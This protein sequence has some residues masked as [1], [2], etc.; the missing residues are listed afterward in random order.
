MSNGRWIYSRSCW[1][2]L[3]RNVDGVQRIG[4]FSRREI[5]IGDEITMDYNFSHF[6]EAVAC[7]CGTALCR[8]K[9]GRI[10]KKYSI[11]GAP[12][13]VDEEPQEIVPAEIKR[14]VHVSSLALLKS[15]QVQ[16]NCVC[17]PSLHARFSFSF[18]VAHA[19]RSAMASHVRL[20]RATP[21]SEPPQY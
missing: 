1:V 11:P 19:A 5:Q 16:Q 18:V 14:P 7:K 17:I 2:Y 4:I 6:G 12:T 8:G 21:L 10:S 3:Y 13:T 15:S 20:P 9:I